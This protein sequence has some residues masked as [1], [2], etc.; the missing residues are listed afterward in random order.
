MIQLPGRQLCSCYGCDKWRH[1]VWTPETE[2]G[3]RSLI[4]TH[5]ILPTTEEFFSTNEVVGRSRGKP[6][7]Q[8]ID[9]IRQR[10]GL[11]C[12]VFAHCLRATFATRLAEQN[13]SAPSLTYVMGWSGLE[14]SEHYI[15]SSMERAH[16]EFRDISV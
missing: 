15:Q 2:A 5:E 8:R 10:S 14:A 11:L 9:R 3:I 16:A 7:E 12:P 13:I 1:G 6:L 4:I